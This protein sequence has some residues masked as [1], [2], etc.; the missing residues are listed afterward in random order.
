MGLNLKKVTRGLNKVTGG[1][2]SGIGDTISNIFSPSRKVNLPGAPNMDWLSDYSQF[3]FLKKPLTEGVTD[4]RERL[5]QDL[6]GSIENTPAAEAELNQT[7]EG[8]DLDT[9]QALST[10]RQEALDRG[11]G[12]PGMLSEIEASGL[13]TVASDAARTKASARTKYGLSREQTRQKAYGDRYATGAQLYSQLL[14]LNTGRKDLLAQLMNQRDLARATG[15]STNYGT[16][17][18]AM[19]KNYQPSVLDDILRNIQISLGPA[20]S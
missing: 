17:T 4:D 8:I 13:G 11:L 5:F 15:Q 18:D 20:K 9:K 1:I 10:V 14:G 12:G 6:L 3:D 7:L 2:S 16:M 19:I